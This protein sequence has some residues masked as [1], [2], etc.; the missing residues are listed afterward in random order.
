MYGREM[1]WEDATWVL[2][3]R[4]ESYSPN[5]LKV[6]LRAFGSYVITSIL[7]IGLKLKASNK[8][9]AA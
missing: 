1:Q 8:D 3:T 2:R 9:F 4:E 5:L 6:V 7:E